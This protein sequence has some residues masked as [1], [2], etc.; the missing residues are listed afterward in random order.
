MK[1]VSFI[2]YFCLIFT[3]CVFAQT[4]QQP[5]NPNGY[6]KFYYDN[7][8]LSSEGPMRDGKPDGYWKTYYQTG[9]IKSEGNRKDFELDSAWKFYSEQGKIAFEYTYRNGKKNGPL[10]TFDE[11][12]N[13]VTSEEYVNNM[14]QGPTENFYASGKLQKIIP[15]VEGKEQGTGYEYDTSGT[16]ITITEYKAG[17]VKNTERL[18]RRDA[19]GLK[20]G[21]WKTFFENG[22]VKT[23]GH[24]LDDKKNGYF[25]EYNEFGNLVTITKWENGQ[26]VKN[27]PELAKIETVI[28]YH[29]NGRPKE[30]GNYKD[31]VPEGVFRTYSDSGTIIGAEVYLEG[32]LV[33]KGIFDAAGVK[34]GHWLEYYDTGELR[35]EGDYKDGV[36]VGSWKYLYENQKT[37]QIGKYDNKGRPTGTWKWYFDNDQILREETYT[38]G[39]RNGTMTEYNEAGT[40]ITQGEYVDG[41]K[42]GHWFFQ[43]DD[44]REEGDYTAGER[45]GEWKHT[46]TASGN[47][48]FQ[49]TFIN[50]QPDGKQTWWYENGRVWQ[51]GKFVY[52]R[53][54]GDW[55]YFDEEGYMS[56]V[57]TYKDDVEIKFDGTKIKFEDPRGVD[58]NGNNN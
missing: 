10:K 24:F 5:T 44:Y 13:V 9:K 2:F 48:R 54:D 6:N 33:G 32:I 49:G 53:K 16:I 11:K 58:A 14:K 37:E 50:G 38:D 56:L 43:I 31:G 42:E 35:G 20:Q 41:L 7:G 18:N 19:N 51:E 39:L 45:N 26:L 52:G 3:G 21:A 36:K 34:Q 8:K 23:E 1:R 22:K 15:F 55:K 46:Y 47:K 57:V 4:P 40:I 28:T 12:G 27:P 25:K 30:I 29:N 17:F